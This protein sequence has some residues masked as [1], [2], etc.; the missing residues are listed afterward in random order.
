MVGVHGLRPAFPISRMFSMW[1]R[2][3][4]ACGSRRTTAAPGI[5]SSMAKTRNRLEPS[6]L[7]L[8]TATFSTLPAAKGCTG[9]TSLS[10]MESTVQPMRAKHGLILASAMA[11]RFPLLPSIPRTPNRIFAAVLG[12]PYGPN[13]ER[14]IFRSDEGGKTWDK[15]LYKDENTGG[16]DVA[17]DPKNPQVVY[18]SLWGER[19]GPWEDDNNYATTN[20]GLFKSTDGGTTWKQ[21]TNGLPKDLVQI[22]VAIAASNPQRLYATV[23]TKEEGS[24]YATDKGLECTVPMTL[25]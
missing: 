13:A 19:L 14:G 24:G 4:A 16:S 3:M 9:P 11:S 17:I 21:L 20:G 8:L 25:G 22:N 7:R 10:E 5:R 6:R 12:H 15:V 23:S 18:A 1:D 2:W